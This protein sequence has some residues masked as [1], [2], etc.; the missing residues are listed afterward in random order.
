MAMAMTVTEMM[1]VTAT[2][3]VAEMMATVAA[4][5]MMVAAAVMATVTAYAHRPHLQPHPDPLM[6]F[7]HFLL[8]AAVRT[9]APPP[10]PPLL[11]Y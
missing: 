8:L 3:M 10:L 4:T 1:M 2:M 5:T 11:V 6:G 9:Q 7:H